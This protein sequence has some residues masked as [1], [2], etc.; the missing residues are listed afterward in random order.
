MWDSDSK[1]R[2]IDDFVRAFHI[3]LSQSYAYGDT[4]GDLSMLAQVAHPIAINPARALLLSIR[5]QP[6]LA[7]RAKIIIERKDVIY[8]LGPDVAIIEQDVAAGISLMPMG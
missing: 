7:A 5:R 6:E 4:K 3:D 1:N 8:E 2:A